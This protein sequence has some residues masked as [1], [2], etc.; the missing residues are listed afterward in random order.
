MMAPSALFQHLLLDRTL[1]EYSLHEG[2]LQVRSELVCPDRAQLITVED[3]RQMLLRR[4]GLPNSEI[5]ISERMGGNWT[6]FRTLTRTPPEQ[7]DIRSL[8]LMGPNRL[9][10]SDDKLNANRILIYEFT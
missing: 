2:I 7:I 6:P 1:R 3:E 9:A 8:S 4:D 5:S 10:V